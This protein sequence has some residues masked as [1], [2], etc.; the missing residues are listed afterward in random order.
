[1][2]TE[3]PY[4]RELLT[5]Y[6]LKSI[7]SENIEEFM[8]LIDYHN[9]SISGS[10]IL[11]ILT[12]TYYKS[13]DIDLYIDI[14]KF[15]VDNYDLVRLIKLL[16]LLVD[17]S[18]YEI[19]RGIQFNDLICNIA[20]YTLKPKF[21]QTTPDGLPWEY[22]SL[23]QYI[24]FYYKLVNYETNTSI[25]LLFISDSMANI[26]NKTFD[27]DII[28][29]YYC[30]KKVYVNNI[31]AIENKIATISYKHFTNR[32]S[33]VSYEFTNFL[34]RFSKYQNRGYKIY[35]GKCLL[36]PK[37]MNYILNMYGM[38]HMQTWNAMQYTNT[39][40]IGHSNNILNNDLSIKHLKSKMIAIHSMNSD[41]KLE[42]E[43]VKCARHIFIML[44]IMSKKI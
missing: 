41:Y 32:I 12:N 28:K 38:K 25:E 5:K 39:S 17:K 26:I 18:D 2:F 44:I 4:Q 21:N 27:M 29:N 20:E 19:Q 1:M 16:A 10:S 34:N 31:N 37:I 6:L 42:N 33:Q 35:I 24:K 40:I 36:T 14:S 43:E 23:Q 11:Q 15:D 13:S 7:K 8:D 30:N 22:T 9:Y 3:Q